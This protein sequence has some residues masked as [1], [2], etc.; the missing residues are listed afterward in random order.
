MGPCRLSIT[1]CTASSSFM[2]HFALAAKFLHRLT[3]VMN[4]K[5]G[6]IFSFTKSQRLGDVP[7]GGTTGWWICQSHR[8][9]YDEHQGGEMSSTWVLPLLMTSDKGGKRTQTG[10]QGLG[11]PHRRTASDDMG[12]RPHCIYKTVFTLLNFGILNPSGR[13]T[14]GCRLKSLNLSF[15]PYWSA[16]LQLI[17]LPQSP[18][19]WEA[20]PWGPQSDHSQTFNRRFISESLSRPLS[21]PI[22]EIRSRSSLHP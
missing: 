18:S 16:L 3:K 4:S 22:H 7:P 15:L 8:K 1:I 2:F 21:F 14:S 17:S 12:R 6:C 9:N 5:A 19:F 10:N 11:N 13:A 20:S